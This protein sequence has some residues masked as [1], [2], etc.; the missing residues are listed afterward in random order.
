LNG[1]AIPF[2]AVTDLGVA[3]GE[4]KRLNSIFRVKDPLGRLLGLGTCA[5][6]SGASFD[7]QLCM[8]KVLAE[9]STGIGR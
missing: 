3:S 1:A 9:P 8:V 2:P 4:A 5:T 6:P 7:R